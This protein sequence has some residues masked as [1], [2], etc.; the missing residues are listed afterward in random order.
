[1]TLVLTMSVGIMSKLS[2]RF[3]RLSVITVDALGL[4]LETEFVKLPFPEL[5]C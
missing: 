4:R 3:G 5:L 1:M 2:R